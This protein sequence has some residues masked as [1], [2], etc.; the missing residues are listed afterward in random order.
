MKE[1]IIK[2]KKKS[3]GPDGFSAEF[4]QTFREDLIPIC[5]K[6]LH[7]IEIKETLP[8]SSYEATVI[9]ILKPQRLNKERKFQINRPYEH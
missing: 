1:A 7:K 6:L 5:L 9:V 3:P 8:N 2:K 4:Y